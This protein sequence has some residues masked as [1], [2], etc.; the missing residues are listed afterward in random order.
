VVDPEI[1]LDSIFQIV[2]KHKGHPITVDTKSIEVRL[3]ASDSKSAL[4][5]IE[6][7]GRIVDRR[8]IGQD[9]TERF[10]D[11]EIR[12]ENALKSRDRLLE[13]LNRAETIEDIVKIEKELESF[14][15]RID[16]LKGNLKRFSSQLE[17]ARIKVRVFAE[18][19]TR[20]GPV[21]YVFYQMYKGVSWLFVRD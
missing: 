9:I 11:Q 5:N 19:K 14:N 4:D 6:K 16:D 18:T 1:T 17:F 12:L 21:G 8:I 2:L 13:L 3:P 20:P 15:K 10:E 7:L